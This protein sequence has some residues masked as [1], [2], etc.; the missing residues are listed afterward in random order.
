MD[1][2]WRF[3]ARRL[4]QRLVYWCA[5][6]EQGFSESDCRKLYSTKAWPPWMKPRT[7]PID[8]EWIIRSDEVVAPLWSDQSRDD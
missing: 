4:P 1:K 6:R 5:M 2:I 3:I 8:P 7:Y